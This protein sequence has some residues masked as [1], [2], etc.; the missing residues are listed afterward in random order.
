[1]AA[2]SP[3]AEGWE[4]DC[5]TLSVIDG[6]IGIEEEHLDRLTERFYRVDKMRIKAA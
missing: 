3:L 5:A 2:I 1:M 4:N 6:G